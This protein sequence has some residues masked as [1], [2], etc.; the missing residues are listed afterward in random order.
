MFAD[1]NKL[2][3]DIDNLILV[4]KSEDL[5]MN[6][7]KLIFQ[8]QELTKTGHL[9]AKVISKT[10]NLK[11]REG[12]TIIQLKILLRLKQANCLL[13]NLSGSLH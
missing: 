13:K 11:K 9:I 6:T 4:S 1:K 10:N 5:I 7:N 8:D 12:L 2:N 3:L